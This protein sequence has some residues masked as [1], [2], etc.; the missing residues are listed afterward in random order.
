M[1]RVDSVSLA[2]LAFNRVLEEHA[3]VER[4]ASILAWKGQSKFD[5]S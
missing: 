2:K 5:L 3:D 4:L 1:Q